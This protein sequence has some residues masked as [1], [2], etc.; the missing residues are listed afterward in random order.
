M[1]ARLVALSIALA[2]V[3]TGCGSDGAPALEE[4]VLEQPGSAEARL[5][6]AEDGTVALDGAELTLEELRATAN[7]GP[8]VLVPARRAPHARVIE[9]AEAL[10][11]SGAD[12]RIELD[13]ASSP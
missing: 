12:Y 11:S 10:Q 13:E 2:A 5:T 4:P 8:V 6:I 7:L 1:P 9:A 3:S